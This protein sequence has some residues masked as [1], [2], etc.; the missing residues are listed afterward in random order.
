M[1]D[2]LDIVCPRCNAQPGAGCTTKAGAPTATHAARLLAFTEWRKSRMSVIR[3]NGDVPAMG[4]LAGQEMVALGW[5]LGGVLTLLWALPDGAPAYE[6]LMSPEH[7]TFIRVPNDRDLAAGSHIS[8]ADGYAVTFRGM[9]VKAQR[10][11][12][13]PES[14]RDTDVLDAL[15]AKSVVR[16]PFSGTVAV[17]DDFGQ[18][19]V[20][21]RYDA[22]SS[23]KLA[24]LS[25]GVDVIWVPEES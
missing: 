24:N 19:S 12:R 1:S 16:L 20:S 25:T 17:R 8:T 22:I 23:D 6:A 14:V 7:A 4:F 3:L 9:P 10:D 5:N 18:W 15:A 21:G 2:V 11:P 13:M